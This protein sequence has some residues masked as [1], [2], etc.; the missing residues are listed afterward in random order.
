MNDKRPFQSVGIIG[1]GTMGSGI[2]Q[3]CA[4]NGY[5]VSVYDIN[6]ALLDQARQQIEHQL[7]TL[8]GKGR[9]TSPQRSEILH[10]IRWTEDLRSTSVD[11]II[12]AVVERLE[13]KQHLLTEL[14]AVNE[15]KVLLTT[16]TSSIPVTQIAA[17]LRNPA[18]LAGLHFFNPAPVMKLVEIISGAATHP[19]WVEHLRQFVTSLGKVAAVAKDSPGFIVN[20]VARPFYTEA[21]QLLEEGVAD[22]ET[23]D[24]LMKSAGFKMGPFELMDLIGVDT[25]LAVTKSIYNGFFQQ[26]RFRP[27]RTQQQLVDAGHLGRK[28]GKG[29][30]VYPETK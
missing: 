23:I 9:L 15:G 10:R 18:N 5:A 28:T 29:F 17:S 1:A 14:E 8:V 6:P 4:Q 27:S 30:Y 3:V 26:A 25:N 12:E 11:L 20:R 7:Q 2:A 13:V 19:D 16:N 22:A 24:A 21:I